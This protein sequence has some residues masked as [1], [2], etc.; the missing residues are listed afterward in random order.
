MRFPR[1]SPVNWPRAA[2]AGQAFLTAQFVTFAWIFFRAPDWNAAWAVMARIA[3]CTFSTA[4]ISAPLAIVFA[5]A[6]VAHYVPLKW[7]ER[8]RETYAAAPFYAQ[9]AA[10]VLLALSLHY[11]AATGA[12]PFIYTRF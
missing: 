6:L 11:V 5:V 3:S 1:S 7:Y 9:A 8:T 12:T 2:R 4:N 10:L